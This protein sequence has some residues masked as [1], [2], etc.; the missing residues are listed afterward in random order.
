MFL[1]MRFF[2]IIWNPSWETEQDL[3]PGKYPGV[4]PRL[5]DKLLRMP[6]E[7]YTINVVTVVLW[8]S[9]HIESAVRHRCE[10]NFGNKVTT[11]QM[12][13]DE[14]M[15][16]ALLM[17]LHL[18]NVNRTRKPFSTLHAP[19]HLLQFA[20]SCKQVV[21]MATFLTDQS[22]YKTH[23]YTGGKSVLPRGRKSACLNM[24]PTACDFPEL[25]MTWPLRLGLA[26]N[27]HKVTV[28]ATHDTT[29]SLLVT[30]WQKEAHYDLSVDTIPFNASDFGPVHNWS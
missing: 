1:Y 21:L 8:Y 17:L 2:I 12:L 7:A 15:T 6:I 25:L 27:S 30:N 10:K 11:C 26:S 3:F 13:E 9:L 20:Q 28:L 18:Y 24:V 16:T 5:Q 19:C 29:N 23:H 4:S 22:S 14:E